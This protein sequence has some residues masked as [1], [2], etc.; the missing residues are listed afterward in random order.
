MMK[1]ILP[2]LIVLPVVIGCVE[3]T[4]PEI[5]EA[6]AETC[7][8][9]EQSE[10]PRKY[11]VCDVKYRLFHFAVEI[12]YGDGSSGYPNAVLTEYDIPLDDTGDPDWGK[13]TICLSNYPNHFEGVLS[14]TEDAVIKF[15]LDRTDLSVSFVK[16]LRSGGSEYWDDITGSC[17]VVSFE[18]YD[19]KTKKLDATT[20]DRNKRKK[21]RKDKEAGL[22]RVI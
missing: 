4:S 10:I 18:I 16:D 11:L 2:L 13:R 3:E 14:T 5:S 19:A 12:S 22:Q 15:R 21:D 20:E 8:H 9:F 17:E 7:P 6:T 1:S